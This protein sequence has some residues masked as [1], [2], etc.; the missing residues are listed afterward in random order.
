MLYNIANN[1]HINKKKSEIRN[2]PILIYV[3]YLNSS[4]SFHTHVSSYQ[5][6]YHSFLSPFLPFFSSLPERSYDCP[7]RHL[8]C[9]NLIFSFS[10]VIS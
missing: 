10:L 9:E 7:L 4:W 6:F 3:F 1:G 2:Y 8:L 5:P